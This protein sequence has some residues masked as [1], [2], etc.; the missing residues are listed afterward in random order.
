MQGRGGPHNKTEIRKKVFKYWHQSLYLHPLDSF[1]NQY[2]FHMRRLL[3]LIL[4]LLLTTAGCSKNDSADSPSP[5]PKLTVERT[6]WSLGTIDNLNVSI[7]FTVN[8][9]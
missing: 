1:S 3:F 8:V 2:L 6:D 5:D 9:D 4:P 7:P